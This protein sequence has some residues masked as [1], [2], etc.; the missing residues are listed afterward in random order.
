MVNGALLLG[1]T[2]VLTLL[3]SSFARRDGRTRPNRVALGV[4]RVKTAFSSTLSI[5]AASAGSSFETVGAIA[6]LW[7]RATAFFALTKARLAI[8]VLLTVAVGF[9]LGA[10]GNWRSRTGASLLLTLLGVAL[11]AGGGGTEINISNAIAIR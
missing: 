7:C 5:P 2:V 8:L 3:G 1:A 4:G 11:V 10:R 9:V 6:R